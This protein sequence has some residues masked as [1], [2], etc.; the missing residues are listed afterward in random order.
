[1]D[2]L[3]ENVKCPNVCMRNTLNGHVCK[4]RHKGVLTALQVSLQS[5]SL[6]DMTYLSSPSLPID[7]ILE[8]PL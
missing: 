3:T 7:D 4:V 5:G 8:C 1:M 6:V 2:Q